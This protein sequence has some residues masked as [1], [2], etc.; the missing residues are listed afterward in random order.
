MSSQTK[1][2]VYDDLG[3]YEIDLNI[4]LYSN[5]TVFFRPDLSSLDSQFGNW[6]EFKKVVR[7][8]FENTPKVNVYNFACS[9]GSETYSLATALIDEFKEDSDKFFPIKASDLDS[10][11][12]KRASSGLVA[13]SSDDIIRMRYNLSKDTHQSFETFK[14]QN[15][16]DFRYKYYFRANDDLR[17]K[18]EFSQGDVE[19]EIT[20][21]A[22]EN[23]LILCRNFWP[24]LGKK[25]A[26]KV[27][28]ELLQKLD[29]TSIVAIGSFDKTVPYIEPIFIENGFLEISPNVYKKMG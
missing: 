15:P 13:C 10:E 18:I 25:K 11:M 17:S 23:N 29:K 9:D 1:K 19:E 27:L 4:L 6:D 7:D 5:F 8:N 20:K 24:Y 2:V 3:Q 12:V 28:T 26:T 14:T 21:I 16:F 22:P